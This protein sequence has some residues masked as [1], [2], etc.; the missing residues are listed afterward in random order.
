[1]FV[2]L[3]SLIY[4]CAANAT[5][6][7]SCKASR[8]NGR[9]KA[10]LYKITCRQTLDSVFQGCSPVRFPVLWVPLSLIEYFNHIPVE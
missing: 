7:L 9:C 3:V 6:D 8:L 4:R 10:G 2:F 1:M 5:E